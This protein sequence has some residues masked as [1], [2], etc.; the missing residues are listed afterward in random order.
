MIC[1]LQILITLSTSQWLALVAY[2]HLRSQSTRVSSGSHAYRWLFFR[3]YGWLVCRTFCECKVLATIWKTWISKSFAFYNHS[4]SFRDLCPSSRSSTLWLG[5]SFL[6]AWILWI[7]TY[8]MA[9]IFI[10]PLFMVQNKEW[11]GNQSSNVNQLP[12]P[13]WIFQYLQ[14]KPVLPT[15]RIIL[16]R[17]N[18]KEWKHFSSSWGN[19]AISQVLPWLWEWRN[20]T[21]AMSQGRNR[22]LMVLSI[23]S[24]SCSFVHIPHSIWSWQYYFVLFSLF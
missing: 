13:C 21:L 10:E 16:S 22:C 19:D 15:H 17:K 3:I 18:G 12:C 24:A 9:S 23:P 11:L 20:E 7:I 1:L 14:Q 6:F 2:L 8:S 4:K 5:F